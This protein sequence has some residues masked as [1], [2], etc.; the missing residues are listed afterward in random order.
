M[1]HLHGSFIVMIQQSSGRIRFEDF[2]LT[3][4]SSKFFYKFAYFKILPGWWN[5]RLGGTG[6]RH[7]GPG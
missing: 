5:S 2:R 1:Q 7:T 3:E 6:I 4:A